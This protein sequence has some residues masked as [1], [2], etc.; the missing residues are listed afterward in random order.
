MKGGSR[1]RGG[2]VKKNEKRNTKKE[3][4]NDAHLQQW[5]QWFLVFSFSLFSSII[6]QRFLL[7]KFYC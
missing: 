5:R 1:E 7:E 4:N 6:Y 2:T 3:N